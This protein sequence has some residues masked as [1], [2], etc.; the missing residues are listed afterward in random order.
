M[1]SQ[2]DKPPRQLGLGKIAG[3][4]GQTLGR[5]LL[6]FLFGL[7]TVVIIA[8]VLGPEGNGQ[9][10]IALLLPTFL[11]T[12]LE[13][14]IGAANVYYVGRQEVTPDTAFK[15]S[16]YIWI[17]LS[18]IGMLIGGVLIFF[19]DD[20]LFPGIPALLLWLALLS[21]PP[22]L[23][24]FYLGSLLQAVQDF[25]RYNLA[26]ISS[27]V[28][29]FGFV[30]LLLVFKGGITA[31]IVAIVV[32][33]VIN[34]I[35]HYLL[36]QHHLRSDVDEVATTQQDINY[37]QYVIQAAKYGIKAHG[38]GILTFINYRADLFFVNLMLN[39]AMTGVYVIALSLSEK[40]WFLSQS[41]SA[42][43]LPRLA[44]LHNDDEVRKQL[45]PLIARWTLIFT[46]AGAIALAIIAP[47]LIKI[48]FGSAYRETLN[49][50][51]FLL[52]G[53]VSWSL[54]RILAN[55]LASRGRP[56]LNMYNMAIVVVI[57]IVGNIVLI[58]RMGIT[59]AALATTIAYLVAC[60]TQV[61]MYARLSK[62]A[63]HEVFLFNAYD[64]Q[65]FHQLQL[66]LSKITGLKSVNP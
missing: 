60:V 38:S 6:G 17:S 52:P 1:V 21:F 18:G 15:A 53:I 23:L 28:M 27:P 20:I 9:Y 26:T 10:A 5:Q 41:I 50:L 33:Q 49:P 37:K 13:L 47:F 4:I 14:G 61:W 63:W 34:V 29:M 11:L 58:P 64:A 35:I 2:E 8:R 55:D 44:E 62:N 51:L 39:P 57:N 7:G 36:V 16:L 31:V 45:T 3:N 40:L 66:V 43:L 32:V 19:Y 24:Q 30:S 59:G 42:V 22:G 54:V 65:I 25:R 12:L 48:L 56:E 46:T